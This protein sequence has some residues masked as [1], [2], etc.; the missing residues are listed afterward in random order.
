MITKKPRETS[1]A[2]FYSII[3]LSDFHHLAK[4]PVGLT[5]S[6]LDFFQIPEYFH[7][8]TFFRSN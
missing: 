1:E 4:F 3:V 5:L 6:V 8:T 7:C 2:L